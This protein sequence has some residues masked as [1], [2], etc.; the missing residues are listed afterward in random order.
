MA[1]PRSRFRCAV[2]QQSVK[3]GKDLYMYDPVERAKEVAQIVCQ[4]DTRKYYRF[5]A[6]KFYG[7][8]ATAD[9]VGCCLRCLFCWSWREVVKPD[10]Y[11]RFYSPEAVSGKL[12]NIA[13]KKGFDRIRISGNEPTI[14]RRH[15]LRVLE[16]IPEQIQFVLETNGIL[17]GHDETYAED[18]A[19]FKNLYVRVSIK[20]ATEG[21]FSTLT[22]ARPEGFALQLKALE[23]LYR[24]G[25]DVQAAV[26]VSFSPAKNVMALKERLATIA[27][28]F[29]Y[30]EIETLA[31]YRDVEQ[32]LQKAGTW[33]A[34]S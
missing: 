8:I 10:A 14:S 25:V 22:G 13:R 12:V 15:L 18:L 32:R 5:R 29:K 34:L 30:I 11:G 21:E 6:A 17:I 31:L 19:G 4:D 23:N 26:M 3:D 28:A 33:Y 7:G 9:C 24:A 16:G 2:P 20:G 27:P 1:P